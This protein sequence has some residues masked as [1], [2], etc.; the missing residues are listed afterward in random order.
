MLEFLPAN[1]FES[2]VCDI[3]GHLTKHDNNAYLI[4]FLASLK[5]VQYFASSAACGYGLSRGA[6]RRLRLWTISRR[7]V[8]AMPEARLTRLMYIRDN[9]R[10]YRSRGKFDYATPKLDAEINVNN[11]IRDDLDR[12]KS[13]M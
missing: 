13:R 12:K 4:L 3:P 7:N 9:R 6:V 2:V 5:S 11:Q 8:S 10:A 1:D